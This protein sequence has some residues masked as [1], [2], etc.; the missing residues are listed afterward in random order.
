MFTSALE[1]PPDLAEI[2]LAA[3]AD[4]RYADRLIAALRLLA[5]EAEPLANSGA[6]VAPD[7][8]DAAA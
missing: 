2:G 5:K 6:E 8:H 1:F 4:P 7:R 3:A